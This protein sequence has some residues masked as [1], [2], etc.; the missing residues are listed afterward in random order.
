[1]EKGR[2]QEMERGD[3]GRKGENAGK[4]G[5]EKSAIRGENGKRSL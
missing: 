3:T 1:M 5:T 4:M 2:E